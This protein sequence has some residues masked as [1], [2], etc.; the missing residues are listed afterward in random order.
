MIGLQLIAACG[1]DAVVGDPR[2]FPHPVRLIGS[3]IRRYETLALRNVKTHVGR[4]AAGMILAVGLP[5]SVFCVY[6]VGD[7]SS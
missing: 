3:V 4:Y 6:M 7:S 5:T 1:L 2:W